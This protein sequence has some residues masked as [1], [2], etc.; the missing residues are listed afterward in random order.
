MK[1]TD[2]LRA[3][4]QAIRD[5]LASGAEDRLRAIPGVTHVS[6][7]LKQTQNRATAELCIRV[8]VREKLDRARLSPSELIPPEIDG[9]PTDVNVVEE[10]EFQADTTRYR[11]IIGGCQI[12]NRI[13]DL[14]DSGRP[15][16][17]R[18]TLGC[19]AIDKTD[20]A[21]V[22]LSNWHV[23][24]AS[25]G[26]KGDKVFQPSPSAVP[27]TSLADL[28][29]RPKDDQD[30]I[31]ILRRSVIND[32]VD[33]AIAAID[34]SSCCHC[35][36]IHFTNSINGLNEGGR[37]SRNTIVGDARAVGGMP[38]FKVGAATRRAEGVV[39]DDNYPSFSITKSG[40]TYT[41]NGQI[42]IENSNTAKPF[43]EHGDSGSVIINLENKIVGLLF[44]ASKGR[45]VKG[46][47]RP[48][49]TL[50]NHIGDVLSALNIRI[51]YSP[52]V[53]VTSGA[54]LTDVPVF[55]APVPEPYRELRARLQRHQRTA[56]LLLEGERHRE[57]ILHLINHCRPVT[58]AW[59]RCQGPALLAVVMGAI[60]DRRHQ[61]PETV[62]GVALH[63]ALERMRGV[64]A[65][66]GSAALR[67]A[68]D[69]A[70][71]DLV[72]AACRSSNDL[73]AVFADLAAGQVRGIAVDGAR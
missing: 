73:E 1:T 44:A 2:Q 49:V 63:E 36:G 43:S 16:I 64:L 40:A 10:F 13:I 14:G 66:N 28:P 61:L 19:T 15:Q 24:F 46:T 48:F 70:D 54:T 42:A 68:F 57:E 51:P 69:S 18:G 7:G 45:T 59:H 34:V 9:I 25:S 33:G 27:P 20:D 58:V 6:V 41:F 53:V 67:T 60:R 4:N 3:E 23:L 30:K 12:T 71:A 5:L 35:C 29:L 8:Y 17:E 32:K 47:V 55:E 21:P 50:A 52:D 62:K 37:P 22:V 31:A 11:P 56:R 26:R 39:I 72:V 65:A 38:V